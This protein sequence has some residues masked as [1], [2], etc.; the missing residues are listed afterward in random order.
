MAPVVRDG[1]G[2][3]AIY[4]EHFGF[5][6]RCLRGLGVMEANL[7]DAVQ[8]VFMIVHRRLPEFR[9][10]SMLRTWL[11]G[12]VR[13]V[14]ANH[15]RAARRVTSVQALDA[16]IE[17]ELETTESGP[18]ERA[19]I[20]QAADFVHAFLESI[21]EKKRELFVLAVLEQMSIPEVAEAL[22]IPLNTAYT[23]LRL[24]RGDFRA[25]MRARGGS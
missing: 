21:S 7:D 12:I 18:D 6:S 9:G 17:E 8:D 2:F 16:R 11:Y 20:R 14:A 25:A 23:R 4:G 15:R 1:T 22:G 10:D 24:V 19:Q 5:V 13:N 3:E